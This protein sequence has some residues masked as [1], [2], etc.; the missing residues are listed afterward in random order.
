MKKLERVETQKTEEK[1]RRNDPLHLFRSFFTPVYLD[2]D[3][4]A[5]FEVTLSPGL[6]AD[7]GFPGPLRVLQS[8]GETDSPS[9]IRTFRDIQSSF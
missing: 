3:W 2:L 7:L 4:S 1:R 5:L 9:N 8:V 6:F